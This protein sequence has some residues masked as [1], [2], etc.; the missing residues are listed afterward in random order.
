M[1]K[2]EASNCANDSEIAAFI[3]NHLDTYDYIK[4]RL[5][6][7]NTLISETDV[8]PTEKTLEKDIHLTFGSFTGTRGRII[9]GRY[10]I[11]TDESIWPFEM[12]VDEE[13]H[14]IEGFYTNTIEIRSNRYVVMFI[15]KSSL[16]Y[17]VDRS[18]R[19]IDDLLSYIGGLFTLVYAILF[20]LISPFNEYRYELM[21]A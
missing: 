6:F 17:H 5:L 9:L 11:Q 18:H 4:V 21:V 3:E 8:A 16:V 2:C 13:G 20:F 19:K 12:T 1:K 15:E 7:V 10:D 14:Y